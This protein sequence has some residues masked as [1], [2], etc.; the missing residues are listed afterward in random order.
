MKATA[1][2][3]IAMLAFIGTA[4]FADAADIHVYSTGAPAMAAKAVAENFAVATGHRLTFTVAQPAT[5]ESDLDAGAKADVVILPSPVVAML[6]GTG[7]L[8]AG[9]AVDLARVGIGV[10][11]RN[12]ARPPDISNVAAIRKLLL[13]ARSIVYPDPTSGG[14]SAGRAIAHMIDEM[15]LTETVRPKLTRT[16]AIGGGVALVAGGN[17]EVGFAYKQRAELGLAERAKELGEPAMRYVEFKRF[18]V[19]PVHLYG[20]IV[21]GDFGPGGL[22]GRPFAALAAFDP[23]AYGCE[24]LFRPV[25]QG[26]LDDGVGLVL[27]EFGPERAKHRQQDLGLHAR[28]VQEGYLGIHEI[29]V[30]DAAHSV[31][32]NERRWSVAF[33]IARIRRGYS[34][35]A[36]GN[37]M[38]GLSQARANKYGCTCC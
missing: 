18:L 31:L 27:A 33:V 24:Q 26:L 34:V 30:D 6:G 17:V 13:Q 32:T 12:G 21:H 1:A 36:A 5:I 20:N 7:A 4:R 35:G 14:G 9:S 37:P 16:S 23:F 28:L 10:V 29:V 25:A 8:R 19:V 15:G 3:A 38:G 22:Y 11:V 2:C